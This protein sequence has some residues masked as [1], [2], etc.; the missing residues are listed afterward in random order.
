MNELEAQAVS[1]LVREKTLWEQSYAF[2]TEKV[3]FNMR[4]LIRQCRK[5]YWGV[6]DEPIDNQTGRRKIWPP[7]TESIVEAVVKNI[8]LDTKD[9]NFRAKKPSAVALTHVVRSIVRHG[10]DELG[11]GELL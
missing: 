4:N 1:I 11:F 5:N 10:L 8:D 2:I 6:F 7:L 9:V 3:A